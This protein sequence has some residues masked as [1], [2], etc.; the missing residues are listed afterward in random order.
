MALRTFGF[1]SRNL[2]KIIRITASR[3]FQQKSWIKSLYEE[4]DIEVRKLKD[5]INAGLLTKRSQEKGDLIPYSF[6]QEFISHYETLI[7]M[8][9][10]GQFF[11]LL[12]QKLSCFNDDIEKNMTLLSNSMRDQDKLVHR[13][14]HQLTLSL[15][16]LYKQLFDDV[17]K[18]NDG[19]GFLVRMRQDL[20]S[21]K[22]KQ[23]S[24]KSLEL[25]AFDGFLKEHLAQW[26]AGGFLDLKQVKWE[27]TSA[28]VLEKLMKYEAVHPIVNWGDFKKRAAIG[29]R[30][31]M[32][33]HRL[34]PGEPL[35]VLYVLLGNEAPSNIQNVLNSVQLEE[36][37][38]TI[39]TATFYSIS[40]TQ[41]GLDG[42]GLGNVLIKRVVDELRNE[43]YNI[44]TFVTL[45]PIPGFRKWLSQ[46]RKEMNDQ[47]F[48]NELL[49]MIDEDGWIDNENK[50]LEN[51]LQ[52]LCARYLLCEKRRG[53]ALDSVA[54]FHVRNGA[55]LWRINSRANTSPRGLNS[56]CGLMVNYKYDLSQLEKNN[57]NYVMEGK[58]AASPCVLD[59]LD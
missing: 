51:L 54:N 24:P 15:T 39:T 8:E 9:K 7:T 23:P 58:I 57:N 16:P 35:V 26:F 46:K 1:C 40:S 42:I 17:S 31:F 14:R 18:L 45:S 29:R 22:R 41:R 50:E 47:E 2:S 28:N 43:F 38:E 48:Q 52:R 34:L 20:L 12:S 25:K 37:K 36:D 32:F 56:S 13:H 44:D 55:S 59:L 6:A 21:F 3:N 5:G 11:Q 33:S 19:V 30:I 49:K 53:F 27:K 4:D 10:K